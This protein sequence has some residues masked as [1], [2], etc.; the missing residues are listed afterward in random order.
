MRFVT[1][2]VNVQLRDWRPVERTS[3]GIVLRYATHPDAVLPI[4]GSDDSLPSAVMALNRRMSK[5]IYRRIKSDGTF[6]TG[7]LQAAVQALLDDDVAL[8]QG[9]LRRLIDATIGFSALG[10]LMDANPKSL[11]RMLSPNGNPSA[12]HLMSITARMASVES[13]RLRVRAG[14]PRPPTF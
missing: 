5:A 3:T 9:L 14:R 6:R 1:V 2:L 13:V 10:A 4:G 11:I 12:R 8:S 7:L